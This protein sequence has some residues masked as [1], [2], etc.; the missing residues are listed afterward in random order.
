MSDQKIKEAVNTRTVTEAGSDA[1]QKGAQ[2]LQGKT[3]DMAEM[4]RRT[5]QEAAQRTSENLELMKR[6][7]ETMASN[8][9]E[10]SSEMAEWAKQASKQ[11]QE[12]TRQLIQARSIEEVLETQ[13]RY[14][15]ENLQSLLDFSA[16]VLHRSAE[17]VS[18]ASGQLQKDKA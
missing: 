5:S 15:R 14:V 8:V 18:E 6:L 7:A 17:R 10:T 1:A 9:R 4:V 16:K 11:Q 3:T 13:N 12:A 2:S